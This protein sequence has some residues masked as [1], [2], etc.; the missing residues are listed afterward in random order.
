MLPLQ[1]QQPPSAVP[2]PAAPPPATG[3]L[4]G[5]GRRAFGWALAHQTAP[6][7]AGRSFST[8]HPQCGALIQDISRQVIK[9]LP[10]GAI[11]AG[12][13]EKLQSTIID[14]AQIIF[15]SLGEGAEGDDNAFIDH[16]LATVI[17]TI[18]DEFAKDGTPREHFIH[19]A[20]ALFTK[21]FPAGVDDPRVPKLFRNDT[22]SWI[23]RGVVNT[24][25]GIDISWEGIKGLF[26]TY[27][28]QTYTAFTAG[29]N[30]TIDD[31]RLP[32]ANQ[33][34]DAVVAKIDSK[35]KETKALSLKIPLENE[36]A[37][38]FVNGA[39]LRLIQG[40]TPE[41]E[42]A[43]NWLLDNIKS[44][45]KSVY[46]AIFAPRPGQTEAERLNEFAE[47]LLV[48]M[49]DTLPSENAEQAIRQILQDEL[50]P[51]VLQPLLPNFLSAQMV[52]DKIYAGLAPYLVDIMNQSAAIQKE[53]TEAQQQLTK[54]CALMDQG[55]TKLWDTLQTK[56]LA[57]S[58]EP[59]P[60]EF[61][62]NLLSHV[63][64][65]TTL[66][67][68]PEVKNYINSQLKNIASIV[69]KDAIGPEGIEDPEKAIAG[70]MDR[71]VTDAQKEVTAI[72]VNDEDADAK[73]L[74]A[75][76]KILA[77][78]VTEKRFNEL[79][80]K[81]LQK[82]NL[83]DVCAELLCDKVLKGIYNQAKQIQ[84]IAGPNFVL[85]NELKPQ[86]KA[87]NDKIVAKL[88]EP[89][90]A[91]MLGQFLQGGG[92]VNLVKDALP[93]ILE[94]LVAYHV[95]PENDKTSE[96]RTAEL[97]MQLATTLMN[98][99]EAVAKYE[100]APNYDEWAKE[101]GAD[102]LKQY[103]KEHNILPNEPI[104]VRA[105]MLR[106][107]SKELVA[108]LFPKEL[109]DALLP[110]EFSAFKLDALL[111]GLCYEYMDKAYDYSTI[112]NKVEGEDKDIKGLQT[113]MIGQIEGYFQKESTQKENPWIA[114]VAKAIFAQKNDKVMGF[115]LNF[116]ALGVLFKQD[117]VVDSLAP[118]IDTARKVFR[119][120]NSGNNKELTKILNVKKEDYAA[121][122]EATKKDHKADIAQFA[123]W[124]TA[125]RALDII[126]DEKWKQ[127]IPVMSKD[128]AATLL[129]KLFETAHAAQNV[130]QQKSEAGALLVNEQKDLKP[131]I[132]KYFVK[133][134]QEL[135][136]QLGSS[137]DV[138]A[139]KLPAMLDALIKQALA[140]T[141]DI[142][143]ARNSAL[144]MAI[145]SV[146]GKLL[147]DSKD[148]VTKIRE[149]V[150]CYNEGNNAKFS[151]MLLHEALPE[152]LAAT[153]LGRV[154]MNEAAPIAIGILVNDI[155]NSQ[156]V[157][158][159]KA[160]GAKAYVNSLDDKG[161]ESL[162]TGMLEALD[163]SLDA[164]GTD[165]KKL[166]EI[167][168]D[169][170]DGL[171]KGAFRDSE[172][173]P[174]IKQAI[175]SVIYIVLQQVLTPK[176]GQ[177]IADRVAEVVRD[178]AESK[179]PVEWLKLMLPESTLKELLP[180]FLRKSVTH[181]KLMEWFFKPY[182][183][184]IATV[185]KTLA[186]E[187]A[188]PAS[189][190]VTKAQG[191]VQKQLAGTDLLGFGGIVEE[192]QKRLAEQPELAPYLNAAVAQVTRAAEQQNIL[193]PRFLSNAL[194]EALAAMD[195]PIDGMPLD[196]PLEAAKRLLLTL[197]PKGKEDLPVP[198]VAKEAL[199]NKLT[200]AF[201]GL[202]LDLTTA[203]RR[204]LFMLDRL[205]VNKAEVEK[206]RSSLVNNE[207]SSAN[208]KKAE[209]LFK[210]GLVKT[211][212]KQVDNSVT[213]P[214]R[215]LKRI[216]LKAVTYLAVKLCFQNRIYSFISSKESDD[217]FRRLIW[218]FVTYKPTTLE[219]D[220]K[221]E[222]IKQLKGAFERNNLAPA[223]LRGTLAKTVEST[224]SNK[225]ILDLI[226]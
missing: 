77:T 66:A 124:L 74:A 48:R 215:W 38:T 79:L 169:Y 175:H 223:I 49:R 141:G 82:G 137:P 129:M 42:A 3:I 35:T 27:L 166:S 214:F 189:D 217:T 155:R 194:V 24:V 107:Q 203:D 131:F 119:T 222:L 86:I 11:A 225:N 85:P 20:D 33:L 25:K 68:V 179:S 226:A 44:S 184:Q 134:I 19:I 17:K 88:E 114:N 210:K 30:A 127:S 120:L 80:P 173:M 150:A 45:V 22:S 147:T 105:Y 110:K 201:Q 118:V 138:L 176:E 130:L 198:D 221:D 128:A 163:N 63:L 211:A 54:I 69:L 187:N 8:A 75:S 219:D 123:Y 170:M 21:A 208:R 29:Q 181:E 192:I 73:L 111:E 132:D 112:V 62:N 65:P 152:E 40:N 139:K 1:N 159:Q 14:L 116:G 165:P 37:K 191:F 121:F 167:L 93:K 39:I 122:A 90:E 216:V 204:T 106:M 162:V 32:G 168:P 109:R 197:F 158:Q 154:L 98:G 212:V 76:K 115:L 53:G 18:Q 146:M 148:P 172:L 4:A 102:R 209:K 144:E 196:M 43:R 101:V 153:K 183:D 200:S 41:L 81:F 26:A 84:N 31:E 2:P 7:V 100:K 5:I 97:V 205:G 164:L 6:A 161:M 224:V 108:K 70:L 103:R 87:L 186:D 64:L 188:K 15:V 207:L 91:T 94:A 202:F 182:A 160:D 177:T 213:G 16:V 50:K 61:I 193:D 10:P 52:C 180:E 46:Q 174:I 23:A 185:A 199:W 136:V 36:D 83:W 171:I 140:D 157:I 28:E 142:G 178:L 92:V 220:T 99:F 56:A 58:L 117:K 95:H 113:Y 96:V 143:L 51:E 151:A 55:L 133:N 149:L 156:K 12:G 135:L 47:N 145:Y 71:I 206:L 218:T 72:L 89:Q 9:G 57:Q 126:G 59:T 104:D 195:A 67:K 13:R 78:V 125:R 60:Y 190:N 34:I